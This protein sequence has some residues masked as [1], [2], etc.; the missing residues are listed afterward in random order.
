MCMSPKVKMP[1][2]PAPPP[3]APPAPIPMAKAVKASPTAAKRM[4]GTGFGTVVLHVSPEAAVGGPLALVRSGDEIELDVQERRLDLLV[5]EGSWNAGGR[6]GSLRSRGS[7][8]ATAGST[9]TT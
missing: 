7:T 2:M 6:P 8:A 9:S 1:D 3:P 4:S 5:G